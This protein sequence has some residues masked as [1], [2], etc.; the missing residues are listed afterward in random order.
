MRLIVPNCNNLTVFDLKNCKTLFISSFFLT[1]LVFGTIINVPGDYSTI[2]EGI[3]AAT[4]GDTV[5]VQAGT[6]VE[7]IDYNGKKIAVIGEDRET[8]I[9]DGNQSGSV[10][11]FDSIVGSAVVLAD[12]TITGGNAYDGGGI[13]CTSSAPTIRDNI[14]TG[15]VSETYG[16]GISC[17]YS[18]AVIINN[19]ITSNSAYYGGGISFDRY[20]SSVIKGNNI[21]GNSAEQGGGI[22][23]SVFSSPNITNNTISGNSANINGG[24]IY[25]YYVSSSTVTN[26]II[27]DNT[28]PTDPNI[29]VYSSDPLFNYCD[30]MGGWE[31]TGNIDTDPLFADPENGNFVLQEGS[32]CIDAGISFFVWEG[33][34]LVNMSEDEYNGSAPDIGAFEYSFPEPENYWQIL[35]LPQGYE[36][37]ISTNGQDRVITAGLDMDDMQFRIYFSDDSGDSWNNIAG[38]DISSV[39]AVDILLTDDNNIYVPD[40]AYGV[41]HSP[42]FGETWTSP[43]E[44][45]P[46]GC[47]AFNIHPS[48]VMFAGLAYTGIGFIHRS[49]DQG[50][51]WTAIPLPD[52]SSNYAV[53]HIHFNSQGHVFLGTINGVYRSTDVGLTWEKVNSGLGGLKVATMTIDADDH[54]YIQTTY[55][56]LYDG[57][58]RSQDN[59]DTWQSLDYY[60]QIGWSLEFISIEGSYYAIGNDP[61]VSFSDDGGV[62]WV[63]INDGFESDESNYL[64]YDLHLGV[65]GHLYLTGRYVYRSDEPVTEPVYDG[66]I[67]HIAT[68]GSDETG[69]GSEDNPFAIIQHG[70]DVASDGDTILVHPGTYYGPI[71]FLSKNL[72]LGSLYILEENE[73]YINETV[74]MIT[75]TDVSHFVKIDGISEPEIEL[76]GFTFQDIYLN[77]EDG[78]Q[79]IIYIEDASPIIINNRFDNFYLFQGVESAVVYCENSS[80]LIMD[81][82]FTDGSVGNGYVL[83]GYILS[84]SSYLTIKNNRFENGYVGFAEPAGFIVSVDSENIIESNIMNNPSM[85]YCYT[86][87][88][89]SILDGSDCIIRNNLILQASGD[90]YG[91]VVASESQY[92]SNNNTFVANSLGYAN[93]SSDGIVSNDIIYGSSNTVYLDE[94]ST[95]QVSYSDLEGGWEG[96]GNIDADPLFCDLDSG[97]YT[98]AKNSPCVGTGE[99]NAN[100]GAF[101]VGCEEILSIE[102]EVIPT[103]F[104]LHQNYPNPFNPVTTLRY[105]LPEQSHVTIVIFDMLGRTVRQLINTTQEAGYKSIIW[106]ATNDYGKLASAGVYLYQIKAGEFV[107]TKKMV[108]LK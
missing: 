19:T 15:N 3:D 78:P 23:C 66:P 84:K 89:I 24:G 87:A 31:G 48:G 64:L 73:S 11:I 2:Q 39:T 17:N 47:A 60:Y 71:D 81:N 94:S 86:C 25:C 107:Q 51:T 56:S 74:L 27:W 22:S 80:S 41:F 93:L 104:T 82:V 58:Y 67:W 8:T 37:H 26:T 103:S 54:I 92:V 105:E 29:S 57:Y 77:A 16:G 72:V 69:E 85:G 88:A 1:T 20:T 83:G 63:Q 7:N 43:G 53:E 4:N 108:L 100:M 91:A 76:N 36:R 99:N 96:E 90:G 95:I 46:E 52:Y 40:F 101:G 32:S 6:Y 35:A 9:I 14:I 13:Y 98:L 49:E 42:D 97:D 30:V 21:S 18:S 65:N 79:A 55:S 12:F 5:F 59:G 33:D 38:P 106:N 70:I 50:E 10:V 68:D 34:T 45:T 28:A 62:T 61:G 44:F 75:N 102:N